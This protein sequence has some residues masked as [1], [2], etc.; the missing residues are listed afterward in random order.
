MVSPRKGWWMGALF[1]SHLPVVR[2]YVGWEIA[3]SHKSIGPR[4]RRAPWESQ[5]PS[6]ICPG[7]QKGNTSGLLH[8]LPSSEAPQG[9][10]RRRWIQNSVPRGHR[11]SPGGPDQCV[12]LQYD[13][14]TKVTSV[15]VDVVPRQL[16]GK[17]HVSAWVQW[18]LQFCFPAIC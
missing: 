17:R 6:D 2:L 12:L 3:G 8:L 5:A 11:Q 4:P 14:Y 1:A 16:G 10:L 15:V 9:C 18:S 7:H 13:W